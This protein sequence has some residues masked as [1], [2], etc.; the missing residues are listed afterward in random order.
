MILTAEENEI[1]QVITTVWV[2]FQ[3][4]SQECNY[5]E[6]NIQ[7]QENLKLTVEYE[8][9]IKNQG[10]QEKCVRPHQIQ[11][12]QGATKKAEAPEKL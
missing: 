2:N 5:E 1:G 7:D 6:R 4:I 8:E 9:V 11:I 3:A 10:D 12:K